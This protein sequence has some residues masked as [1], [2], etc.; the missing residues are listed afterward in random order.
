MK[1]VVF[2][3][4]L[5]VSQFIHAQ[6]IHWLSQPEAQSPSIQNASVNDA[7][8]SA[9]GRF[10]AFT[11]SASNIVADDTNQSSDLFLYDTLMDTVQMVN[12][13]T[14]GQQLDFLSISPARPTSDGTLVAFTARSLDSFDTYL[15]LKNMQSGQLE[16]VSVDDQGDVFEVESDVF[17]SDAGDQI[18]FLTREE[19]DPLHNNFRENLYLKNL[20]NDSYTLLSLSFDQTEEAEDDI[21]DF[22]VSANGRYITFAS[23]ADNLI[24]ASVVGSNVYLLDRDTGST[25]LV[26]VQPNG[27]P[28]ADSQFSGASELG[29]SNSGMVVHE[30][31]NND[32]VAND[33]NDRSDLFYFNGTQN[34]RI[35]LD[36]N[37][38]EFT[39]PNVFSVLF[40]ADSSEIIFSTSNVLLTEDT[41]SQNDIYIY[42]TQ[43]ENLDI[44]A[45][46]P[47]P[48]FPD[49]TVSAFPYSL[50]ADGDQLLLITSS[51]LLNESDFSPYSKL[52]VHD[53]PQQQT[54]LINPLAFNPNTIIANVGLPKMNNDHN[55]V[56][57]DSTTTNLTTPNDQDAI[58]DLFLLNRDTNLHQKV[59]FNVAQNSHDI[60][61]S[62]QYITFTSRFFQ[63][64]ATVDLGDFQVFL[65]DRIN[66]QY[67][68]IAA[69]FFPSV[70]DAGMVVFQSGVNLTN[71][72]T[73]TFS[74]AYLYDPVDSSLSLVSQNESGVAG[75][76]D[77]LQPQINGSAN[78]TSIVFASLA[79]NLVNTDT[80]LTYDVFVVDWPAGDITRVSQ[81]PTLV[82]G[83]QESF[84]PQ[85]DDDANV[86]TFLT[87]ATNLTND[88]YLENTFTYQALLYERS[89][90]LLHLVSQDTNGN[91]LQSNNGLSYLSLSNAGRYVA[92]STSEVAL[93]EDNDFREDV[94]LYDFDQ[95]T[96][97]LISKQT[98][99]QQFGGN[100]RYPSVT[101]DMSVTPSRLGIVFT[102]QGGFTGLAEHPG[103]DEAFLYQQGGPNILL[104]V[105]VSGLGSV[106][107]SQGV[108]CMGTCDFD[109]PLGTNL[110][111]VAVP[112]AGYVFNRWQSSQGQCVDATNPCLLTMDRD[113][114]IN[115]IFIPEN[116]VIFS[117]GFE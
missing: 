91:P 26:T 54:S 105:A 38:Q 40:K 64:N 77:S 79:D 55:W 53:L 41:N 30:S 100:A 85:I 24:D 83:N 78:N 8:Y 34:I 94:Y 42:D 70:N 29:V 80:N 17:L 16:I 52:Y 12:K 97:S 113:K 49:I 96:T 111:L 98:N 112:D 1:S 23:R 13:Q 11:S 92:Y 75:N 37:G 57:Y 31:R 102:A 93:S 72:D 35:N 32:L 6:A 19:I 89:T 44:L 36:P 117:T 2:I 81:T 108:S 84:F 87:L 43:S 14:N 99:N 68:Q 104:D 27:N 61:P 106:S 107:G 114:Q 71:E 66:Q 3:L 21:R 69:G 33:N 45:F 115:A 48:Q 76:A 15:Y 86:I 25:T 46:T 95:G 9:N 50:S 10:I 28:T 110:T 47:D 101:E 39:S 62:G 90:Q 82:E 4:S 103:Y 63:P 116:D 18:I 65:Y 51:N 7:V 5:C 58:N 56:I 74:D 73:N 59:G 22:S 67:T 88:T 60:S 109:F 20:D